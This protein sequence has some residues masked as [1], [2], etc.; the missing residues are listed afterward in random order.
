MYSPFSPEPGVLF[1]TRPL[2]NPAVPELGTRWLTGGKRADGTW[3]L[4]QKFSDPCLEPRHYQ[5]DKS[6]MEIM[7]AASA[8]ELYAEDLGFRL[9]GQSPSELGD[10]YFRS[11]AK[12]YEI[13]FDG[14]GVPQCHSPVLCASNMVDA[15]HEEGLNW[16]TCRKKDDVYILE[17]NNNRDQPVQFY[18][19]CSSLAELAQKMANFESEA[20]RYG[21]WDRHNAPTTLP[22][23]EIGLMHYRPYVHERGIRFID[24]GWNKGKIYEEYDEV[25]RTG[26]RIGFHRNDFGYSPASSYTYYYSCVKAGDEYTIC[27]ISRARDK[28][29]DE[30]Q[31]HEFANYWGIHKT[32]DEAL[33]TLDRLEDSSERGEDSLGAL[34]YKSYITKR[35]LIIGAKNFYRDMMDFVLGETGSNAVLSKVF[36]RTNR[37]SSWDEYN[38]TWLSLSQTNESCYKYKVTVHNRNAVYSARTHKTFNDAVKDIK[39][40]EGSYENREWQILTGEGFEKLD[41]LHYTNPHAENMIE[42]ARAR[43]LLYAIKHPSSL[44]A[45]RP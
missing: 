3:I 28:K 25:C 36:M 9:T 23:S 32:I 21:Y 24:T 13:D 38:F 16:L 34:Y 42:P 37:Y 6:L 11:F 10:K 5:A 4:T 8:Y 31:D 14:N 40:I 20:S 33:F 39:E 22:P 45:A 27:K 41:A 15:A 35:G 26:D 29:N 2:F 30:I 7:R 12:K 18:A 17:R 19:E 43:R 1:A 44:R